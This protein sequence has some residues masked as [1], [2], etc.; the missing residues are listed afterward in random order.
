MK[1]T[2]YPHEKV[3][4][5]IYN[6]A[7]RFPTIFI[8]SVYYIFPI[9]MFWAEMILISYIGLY[10]NIHHFL[11]ISNDAFISFGLNA[12]SI[13]QLILICCGA[14]SIYKLCLEGEL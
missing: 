7:N 11:H 8:M 9:L 3:V 6:F 10:M 4:E 1:R 14:H 5:N 13:L 12:V 2:L